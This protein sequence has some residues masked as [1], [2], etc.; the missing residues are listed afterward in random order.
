MLNALDDSKLEILKLSNPRIGLFTASAGSPRN[1]YH[2]IDRMIKSGV[3]R[4]SPY[5]MVSSISGTLTF[6]LTSIFKIKGSSCCF[7]SACAS[8]GHAIGYAYDLIK[9][10][11]QDI[12]IV[13]SGEDGD[14]S[15]IVPF[16]GMRA[17]SNNL[18]IN[19]AS[20]PFDSKRDGFVGSGGGVTII[21][22]E[23]NHALNRNS[24][25]YGEIAG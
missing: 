6:N 8:S 19:L 7:V 3:S 21:L 16:A 11:L 12:I 1:L 24:T 2:N 5:G 15:T 13:T 20:K 9:K 17:L 23:L 25:V 4:C 14:F 10:G 18:N 22:E